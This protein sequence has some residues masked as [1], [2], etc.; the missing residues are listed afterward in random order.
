MPGSKCKDSD[1]IQEERQILLCKFI[2]D[3]L[4]DD[5]GV[6]HLVKPLKIQDLMTVSLQVYKNVFFPLPWGAACK[7][8]PESG[9]LEVQPAD[10]HA[11]SRKV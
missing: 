10:V 6:L 4:M 1:E 11:V 9:W 7:V 2:H 8:W 3:S 5:N